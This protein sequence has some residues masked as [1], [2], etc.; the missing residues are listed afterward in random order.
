MPSS[1]DA[2]QRA[3][4]ELYHDAVLKRSLED[5]D[6]CDRDRDCCGGRCVCSF[7]RDRIKQNLR[8][9]LCDMISLRMV[10]GEDTILDE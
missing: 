7:L 2:S 6:D 10:R 9:V 5:D 8:M 4:E 1:L 3:V